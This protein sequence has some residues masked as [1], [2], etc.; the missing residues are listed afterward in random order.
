MSRI[1]AILMMLILPLHALAA[2][3]RHFAHASSE[4]SDAVE[5]IEHLAAHA[6]NIPHHHH[7]EDGTDVDDDFL[8]ASHQLEFDL[9]SNLL[10]ALPSMASP[11]L[12]DMT[13]VKPSFAARAVP[14]VAF[15]P[16]LR[17]PHA[18]A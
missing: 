5:T 8:S 16:P 11:L 12:L 1:I 17:P 2:A 18:P 9:L 14:A 13:H 4:A 10:G 6:E 7:D 15:G 3:E